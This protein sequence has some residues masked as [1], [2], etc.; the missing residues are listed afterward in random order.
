MTMN[1]DTL[2]IQSYARE[3]AKNTFYGCSK[4]EQKATLVKSNTEIAEMYIVD[5]D[6]AVIVSEEQM[7]AFGA[8]YRR[9]L[10]DYQEN[11]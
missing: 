2:T 6:D 11:Y 7:E 1:A 10:L 4:A 5:V 8:E 9:E 3:C